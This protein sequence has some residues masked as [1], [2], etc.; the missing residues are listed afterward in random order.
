MIKREL[1][2][3]VLICE[4]KFDNKK[5]GMEEIF[6]WKIKFSSLGIFVFNRAGSTKVFHI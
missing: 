5:S 6:N 1:N 4:L 2:Y 3:S